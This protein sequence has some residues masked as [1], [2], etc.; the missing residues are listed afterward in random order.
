[1]LPNLSR[2]RLAA[3]APTGM[4]ATSSSM[5]NLYGSEK[6]TRVVL[7][8]AGLTN[9]IKP[10]KLAEGLDAVLALVKAKGVTTIVWDGDLL[11]YRHKDGS[12]PTLA[13][14][15][16]LPVLQEN[17]AELQRF[18]LKIAGRLAELQTARAIGV[19]R[20]QLESI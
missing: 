12:P 18:G 16:V 7:K 2:L 14:T 10:Q 19:V 1:M 11:N 4:G 20:D 13:F 8:I 3:A 9:S 15:A 17:R 5:P 6:S